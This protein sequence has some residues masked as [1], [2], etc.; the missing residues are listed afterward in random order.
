MSA[1]EKN[2]ATPFARQIRYATKDSASD[3]EGWGYFE[4]V[5]HLLSVGDEIAVSCLRADGTW[6]KALFEVW[7]TEPVVTVERVSEWRRGGFDPAERRKM[8]EHH[9]ERTDE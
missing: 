9:Q 4:S 5:A 3:V 7:M 2:F 6:W 1:R 8:T